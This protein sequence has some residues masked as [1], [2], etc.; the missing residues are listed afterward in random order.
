MKTKVFPFEDA[1][2]VSLESI[3][4]IDENMSDLADLEYGQYAE[5]IDAKGDWIVKYKVE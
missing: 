2:I 3:L 1:R 5:S 4:I